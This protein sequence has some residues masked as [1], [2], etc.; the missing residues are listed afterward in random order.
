MTGLATSS[1]VMGLGQS[2]YN[3]QT[4]PSVTLITELL[5]DRNY[6][7]NGFDV[8]DFLDSILNDGVSAE[9]ETDQSQDPG[10]LLP[11]A[12]DAP[13]LSN[14]WASERKSRAAAYGISFDDVDD[15]SSEASPILNVRAATPTDEGSSFGNIPLLTPA[16]ILLSGQEEEGDDADGVHSFY[17]SLMGED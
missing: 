4:A 13:L 16:A 14:P 17:A 12:S 10:M 1:E 9:Q 8:M 2:G 11:G 3:E 6:S 5:D 15:M 7:Q